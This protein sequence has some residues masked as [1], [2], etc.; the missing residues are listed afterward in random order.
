VMSIGALL[1]WRWE[2]IGALFIAVAAAGAGI[3]AA[4]E[5]VP[6]VALV[7]TL[8]LMAPAV[9]LWLSWQH[10]RSPREILALAVLATVLIGGSWAGANTV[11]DHFFGPTH[12]ESAAPVIPIDRVEWVWSGELS[13][14][15]ITVTARTVP[16]ASS[17]RLEVEPAAGGPAVL[18]EEMTPDEDRLVR[19]Q[20]DGLRPETDHR[21]RVVVDGERDEGRGFGEF[22]TPGDG[23]FSFTMT[24]SACARTGSNVAVFDTIRA[25][26]PLFHLVLGDLHYE[27]IESTDPARFIDAYGRAISTPAQSALARQAP[28]AYVWDDHDYGPNDADASFFGRSAS[29][30]AYRAAVPHYPVT[31]GDAPINQAFTIGRVRFV[32]TDQRSEH[33]ADTMLGEAQKAWLLDELRTSSDTHAVVVWVNSVPW[34]GPVTPG[35]DNW[36]G[37]PAER[38]EIAD[39]I[40]VEGIHNLVMLSGDAHMLAVDDGTNSDYST[41]GGAGFPVLH[42]AALDRPG[43]VK[44]GPYSEGAFPG[45]GQFGVLEF[46]DDGGATVTLRFSGR[47]WHDETIVAYEQTFVV[48]V[49]AG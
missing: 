30:Q 1:A 26:D 28:T 35:S 13:A 42:T 24:A 49:L 10:R 15:G 39:V 12:E 5:Y 9:L 25:V 27:N 20:V 34:I 40:A 18:T 45:F 7:L 17:A 36:T 2:G 33:T 44:G 11:H 48:P 22:A 46:V 8:A 41:L 16:G 37:Q 32:L 4:L 29:R 6:G 43:S 14:T 31:E 21:Y 47:N 23:A 38:T 3:F 19:F